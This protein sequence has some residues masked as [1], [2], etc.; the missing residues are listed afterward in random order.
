[1]GQ[2]FIRANRTKNATKMLE[3]VYSVDPKYKKVKSLLE[4]L[5]S[6]KNG[7]NGN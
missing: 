1:M 2:V 7:K 6:P 4:S 5:K 3:H